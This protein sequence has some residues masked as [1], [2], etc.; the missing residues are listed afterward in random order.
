MTHH[1]KHPLANIYFPASGQS[2]HQGLFWD[3]HKVLG[4]VE[5]SSPST[6]GTSFQMLGMAF[7]RLTHCSEKFSEPVRKTPRDKW[8][9]GVTQRQVNSSTM[10]GSRSTESPQSKQHLP[11]CISNGSMTQKHKLMPTSH[12]LEN[13]NNPCCLENRVYK[14]AGVL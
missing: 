10:K 11:T 6:P 7:E 14:V 8:V 5:L 12:F 13:I 9:M 1:I 4:W 3:S 2:P